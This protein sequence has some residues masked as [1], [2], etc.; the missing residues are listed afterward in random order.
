VE[1]LRLDGDGDKVGNADDERDDVD[2]YDR[3]L[4]TGDVAVDGALPR[5]LDNDVSTTRSSPEN[6]ALRPSEPV[7]MLQ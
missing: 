2:E 7:Y 6:Y 1:R 4:S 3:E 5:E